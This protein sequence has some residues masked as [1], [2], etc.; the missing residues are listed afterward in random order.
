MACPGYLLR[1]WR[2]HLREQSLSRAL[3]ITSSGSHTPLER[4]SKTAPHRHHRR[5]NQRQPPHH[6]QRR[7]KP[8][9]RRCAQDSRRHP[10]QHTSRCSS[11]HLQQRQKQEPSQKLQRNPSSRRSLQRGDQRSQRSMQRRSSAARQG[12]K[13]KMR[14]CQTAL[15]QMCRLLGRVWELVC[16]SSCDSL[17]SSTESFQEQKPRMIGTMTICTD[18]F[19]RMGSSAQNAADRPECTRQYWKKI[20]DSWACPQQPRQTR[21]AG[22]TGG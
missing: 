7:P 17:S 5:L 22:L 21:S 14:T 9:R 15:T 2:G 19:I 20:T 11:P 4:M 13:R 12:M 3:Q 1:A 16:G 6:Q 10:R 8:R 18:F